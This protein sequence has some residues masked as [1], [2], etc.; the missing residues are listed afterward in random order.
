MELMMITADKIRQDIISLADKDFLQFHSRLVPGQSNIIGVRVPVLR[1]YAR[2]LSKVDSVETL[3][4]NISND[5]Y[6]EIML[7]GM[8][9]GLQKKIPWKSVKEQIIKFVPKIDN[10]AVCDTFCAG[11]KITR[12]YK[13]QMFELADA[14]CKKEGEYER[15][16]G[17]VILLDYFVEPEYLP[18]IFRLF[19]LMNREGYYV[20]MAVAWALSICLIKEYDR[21]LEYLKTCQLDDFTYNKAIQKAIESYRITKEQKSYL[22]SIK[23]KD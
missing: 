18:K 11:L 23:R 15:R 13:E 17:V 16:F 10:W 5:Y 21:T 20:Q 4:A 9:I 3:L 14:Y 2:K 19:D 12:Q 1:E 7:Q 8:L 22:R 6:E